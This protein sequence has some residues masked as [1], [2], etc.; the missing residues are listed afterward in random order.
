MW[1]HPGAHLSEL[2]V[3]Y[4]GRPLDSNDHA[5]RYERIFASCLLF[6]RNYA[7]FFR[8]RP[9]ERANGAVPA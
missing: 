6:T 2:P 8:L 4:D 5:K 1:Q 7:I 3:A 9:C